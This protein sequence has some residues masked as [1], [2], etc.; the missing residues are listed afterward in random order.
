M[1]GTRVN[2]EYGPSRPPVGEREEEKGDITEQ[3][4]RGLLRRKYSPRTR[5]RRAACP[6]LLTRSVL[7]QTACEYR[8][9]AAFVK[10]AGSEH[11][12]TQYSEQMA[13]NK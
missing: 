6:C 4:E 9:T 13:R 10:A 1:N 5:C 3:L 7:S 12:A 2:V 11:N 8:R